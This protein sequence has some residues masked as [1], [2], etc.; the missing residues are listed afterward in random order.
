V[1]GPRAHRLRVLLPIALLLALALAALA[2]P[3]MA[4]VVESRSSDGPPPSSDGPDPDGRLDAPAPEAGAAPAVDTGDTAWVLVSAA[5]VM[6]MT[7]GLALFYGGMVRKKN[8]MNTIMQVFLIL[9][10]VSLQWAVLGYSLAFGPSVGGLVGNLDFAFLAGVGMEPNPTYAATIPHQAFMAFQMMFAIIT[11][12]LIV[13]A[14]VER[15]SFKALAAFT[16]LW[17]TLVYDPL[18]H[19]V[20]GDGGWL[21]SLGAMDFAGGLVVHVS[22][23]CAALACAIYLGKRLGHGREAMTPHN[24]T[25]V[26]LGTGLL[27]FGWFGFNAGSALGAGGL[28]ANAFVATHLATAAAT[29]AWMA[30]EWRAK[31]KPTI[32]GAASGAVAGLVAVTPASGFVGPMAALVIG[33]AAGGACF[34][35]V[36]MK[37]RLGFDDALDAW[38]VHGVGGIVG[39]V[40][41]GLLASTAVNAAGRNGFLLEPFA[42]SGVLTAQ[43]L[44]VLAAAIFAF[45]MTWAILWVVDRA[46]GLRVPPEHE[47]LGL[48]LAQHGEVGYAFEAPPVLAARPGEATVTAST[49]ARLAVLP[50]DGLDPPR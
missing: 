8:V 38:G 31:G 45:A 23:G 6:L 48:D 35:G 11:P 28:A 47:T 39:A 14:M 17:T 44:S 34:W 5:L 29:L 37:E 24:L 20:W 30:L 21:R 33:F 25:L 4:Q 3:A 19:W 46:I 1:T 42:A 22:A 16:L 18:A 26:M 36:R 9:G 49:V 10:L 15:V 43:V 50:H 13:G 41:T 7:P 40:F 12:A 2:L 32:L 27:W